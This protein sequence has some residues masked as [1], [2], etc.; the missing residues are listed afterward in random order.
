MSQS[1]ISKAAKTLSKLGA[2]KGGLARAEHLSPERRS[3]IGQKAAEAR[4]GV[5]Q[6]AYEGDMDIGGIVISCAVLEDETRVLTQEAFLYAI[7]RARK[8]KGGQGSSVDN[9]IPFLAAKNLEPFISQELR[10]STTPI[11]F[12]NL[13]GMRAYGYRAEII[14][15]VCNVYLAARDA[16]VL[17]QRQIHIAKRCEILIRGF[18][19]VGIIALVDE[20]TGYQD[21]RA[22][23]AL[24]KILE[25]YISNQ[26]LKW[27]KTF[28]DEFYKEIFRLKGWKYSL[29]G[30]DKRPQ[31]IGKYTNDLV[32][33]R[34]APFVLEE[35]ERL[36]PPNEKGRR[37]HKNFQ[38]L[39]KDI[40]HPALKELIIG[41]IAL[42]KASVTWEGFKTMLR[43]VYPRCNEQLD[44]IYLEEYPTREETDAEY[45]EV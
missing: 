26:L 14:P 6:A 5:R 29:L 30:F 23:K 38:W 11:I 1:D 31:I 41:E 35:L 28:P 19:T 44:L 25:A 42:M 37:K 13:R 10:E 20:A 39:T 21:V 12:R 36:N 40:G 45:V 24:E 4:W 17:T 34:L 2:S 43:R 7:G 18:A 15:E 16:Q 3:A 22:R 32:Y 27:A 8:A 33:A 9:Q